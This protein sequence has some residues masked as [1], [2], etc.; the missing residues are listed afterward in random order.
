MEREADQR[1]K[2]ENQQ[3]NGDVE[4]AGNHELG[5]VLGSSLVSPGA[6]RKQA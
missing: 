2:R 4:H 1:D 6:G 5:H 3:L